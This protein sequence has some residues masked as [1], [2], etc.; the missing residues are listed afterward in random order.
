MD[1]HMLWI[2]DICHF[3]INAANLYTENNS[4]SKRIFPI[5]KKRVD[6]RQ[7]VFTELMKINQSNNTRE[8]DTDVV[9]LEWMKNGK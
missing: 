3:A 5:C 8:I 2:V 7:Q 9:V 1:P 6:K 4:S